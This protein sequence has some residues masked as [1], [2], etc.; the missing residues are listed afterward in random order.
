MTWNEIAFVIF[1]F[2]LVSS[3]S[4]LQRLGEALGGRLGAQ[5]VSNEDSPTQS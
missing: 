2:L 4:V 5:R 3:W 1:I